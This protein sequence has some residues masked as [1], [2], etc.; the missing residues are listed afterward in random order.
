MKS[1]MRSNLAWFGI[2]VLLLIS[3]CE[4]SSEG[5]AEPPAAAV[6][7]EPVAEE[8]STADASPTTTPCQDA[9]EQGAMTACWSDASRT[10]EEHVEAAVKQLDQLFADKL[11]AE[12]Q[13]HFQEDQRRW[14]EFVSGHCDLYG[15]IYEGGSAAPMTVAICHWKRAQDRMQQLTFLTEELDR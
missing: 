6:Q 14:R 10:E 15:E 3:A 13:K 4:R 2:S 8:T 5:T 12:A 1:K 9:V 11:G 7:T